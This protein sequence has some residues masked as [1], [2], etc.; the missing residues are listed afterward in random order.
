MIGSI[1]GGRYEIEKKIGEG[2]FGDVYSGI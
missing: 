1:I 2:T